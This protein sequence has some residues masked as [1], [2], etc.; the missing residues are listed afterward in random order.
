MTS[1][2]PGTD[3]GRLEY[4]QQQVSDQVN[5]FQ[6]ALESIADG[7]VVADADG[8]F[9]HFNAAAEQILGIGLTDS[10]VDQWSER[11][12]CFLP[13]T[14]TP[15]PA[16]DLPLARAIR[17]EIVH[18]CEVLI[19]H[20]GRPRGVWVSVNAA[21]LR[22]L[23]GRVVGGVAAFRD[24]TARKRLDDALKTTAD[25]LARSNQDLEQFAGAV[26]HDLQQPLR[27]VAR[28]CDLARQRCRGKLDAEAERYLDCAVE[29]A[30]RMERLVKDLLAY[31]RVGRGRTRREPVALG[32]VFAEARDLLTELRCSAAS[33]LIDPLPT[34]RGDATQLGQ[35][36]LNLLDNAIK[37]QRGNVPEIRIS[38][39]PGDGQWTLSVRDNGIGIEPAA[40]GRIFAVFER[41]T[42]DNAYPGTGLGLAI[43][44]RIIEN[45]SGR[46]W[47]ESQ[48]GQGTTIFFTLSDAT[49]Q[50]T[51]RG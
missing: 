5:V 39:R 45:H 25:E 48:P 34:V 18:E 47:A 43:C 49:D 12:G 14:V 46:I 6:A 17:G 37:Y 23:T 24:V 33:V 4:L 38:A 7:V 3:R 26:S 50:P 10:T 16:R 19:R 13:D 22:D 20:A 41:A 27:K 11:Y 9:L 32:R 42:D 44:K 51:A 29:G 21:P 2:P 36:A 1:P 8:H 31:A 28:F 15:Y 40:L 35:L 30:A